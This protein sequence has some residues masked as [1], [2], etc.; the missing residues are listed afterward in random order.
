MRVFTCYFGDKNLKTC[1]G[2]HWNTGFFGEAEAY[3]LNS[4]KKNLVSMK[5]PQVSSSY[6]KKHVNIVIFGP[7]LTEYRQEKIK[8][9][10]RV[11]SETVI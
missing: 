5:P 3:G 6:S 4:T 10:G 11:S 2:I 7:S 9:Y 1:G 8:K